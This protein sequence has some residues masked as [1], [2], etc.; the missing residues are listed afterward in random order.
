MAR[1]KITHLIRKVDTLTGDYQ[2]CLVLLLSSSNQIECLMH[3][4]MAFSYHGNTKDLLYSGNQV[5]QFWC[6]LGL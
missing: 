3:V 2:P 5:N 4:V 1:S 6:S